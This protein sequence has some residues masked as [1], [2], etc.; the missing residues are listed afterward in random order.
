MR[1]SFRDVAHFYKGHATANLDGITV[2]VN[3]DLLNILDKV[4]VEA[5]PF[6]LPLS[7][8]TEDDKRF[9]SVIESYSSDKNVVNAYKTQYLVSKGFDVFGL[10]ESGHAIKSARS[11]T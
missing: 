10:I 4:E 2:R 8:M 6:L 9:L 1:V 11:R 5:R 3:P 7:D